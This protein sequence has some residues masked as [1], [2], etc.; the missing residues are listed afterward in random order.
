MLR[1]FSRSMEPVG[2]VSW[3]MESPVPGVVLIDVAVGSGGC[4]V[5]LHWRVGDWT[6]PPLDVSLT[7]EG[8]IEAFQFVLQDERVEDELAGRTEVTTRRSVAW[9][10][11]V[12]F[13]IERWPADR[14]LDERLE[15]SAER[16]GS[17]ELVLRIGDRL[18][19]L[20]YC[21]A[22]LGLLLGFDHDELV[23]IVLGPLSV[24]DWDSVGA[25]SL[26]G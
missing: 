22:G 24:E 9:A 25:F 6:K 3:R 16:S 2:E 7:A 12:T 8:R 17:D 19:E 1:V 5:P 14:Y 23:E 21:E 10:G 11:A 18:V 20:E 26:G 4:P 15:V 13:A